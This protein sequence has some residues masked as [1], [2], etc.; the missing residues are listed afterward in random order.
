M[1]CFLAI[2]PPKGV[3]QQITSFSQQFEFGQYFKHT[4]IKSFH[5]TFEFYSDLPINLTKKV[6]N[7]LA[8]EISKIDQFKICPGEYATWPNRVQ[9]KVLILKII[10]SRSIHL[11]KELISRVNENYLI[12]TES[13]RFKPH[14]SIGRWSKPFHLEKSVLNKMNREKT[15]QCFTAPELVLFKSQLSQ[16]GVSY[17]KLNSFSFNDE[18]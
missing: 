11:L 17:I 6:S 2:V 8:F 9:S 10:K 13:R 15:N 5:I 3:I 16:T 1:R 4:N 14:I 7:Q 12:N 18:S